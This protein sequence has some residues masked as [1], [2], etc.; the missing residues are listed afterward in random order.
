MSAPILDR[1]A[2]PYAQVG[3]VECAKSL[4]MLKDGGF[5]GWIMV[6]EWEVPDPYEACVKC[7]Q[8]IDAVARS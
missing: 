4:R 3:R 2:L 1:A 5:R 7:K 6:D 8:I